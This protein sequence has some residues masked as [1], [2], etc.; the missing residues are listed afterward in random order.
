MSRLVQGPTGCFDLSTTSCLLMWSLCCT[1][2]AAKSSWVDATGTSLVAAGGSVK[3]TVV[4]NTGKAPLPSGTM[5]AVTT[6]SNQQDGITPI[7]S[8][9]LCSTID[10]SDAEVSL[11]A[12]GS[13]EAEFRRPNINWT[14]SFDVLVTPVHKAAGQIDPFD[15]T[16]SFTGGADVTDAYHVPTIKTQQVYVYTGNAL[17]TPTYLVDESDLDLFF[18]SE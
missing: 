3:Y 9:I 5:V 6:A 18:T 1:A 2:I 7:S 17:R 14:C 4:Y 12:P 16:F 10:S 8:T 15:V 11:T 13:V